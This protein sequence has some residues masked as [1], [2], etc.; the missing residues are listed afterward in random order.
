M[1]YSLR[2]RWLPTCR[3]PQ[4]RRR[5]KWSVRFPPPIRQ[6]GFG[7]GSS[8]RRSPA[9]NYRKPKTRE[10]IVACAAPARQGIDAWAERRLHDRE[11]ERHSW[12]AAPEGRHRRGCRSGAPPQGRQNPNLSRWRRNWPRVDV[13]APRRRRLR[14]NRGGAPRP[15]NRCVLSSPFAAA[16]TRA[17]PISFFPNV[18]SCIV[19]WDAQPRSCGKSA[20]MSLIAAELDPEITLLAIQ[21]ENISMTCEQNHTPIG[22]R[23]PG[24]TILERKTLRV[25]TGRARSSKRS[26]R[27]ARCA[28]WGRSL[29]A[30]SRS[31]CVVAATGRAARSPKAATVR[32]VAGERGRRSGRRWSTPPPPP[33]PANR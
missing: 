24:R 31:P 9:P 22:V 16:P 1:R 28:L 7:M 21:I 2:R 19:R 23:S 32:G 6:I 18:N 30:P 3:R 33:F 12:P 17:W 15:R 27:A 13:C 4:S 25:P 11:R 10:G 5:S 26:E 20:R 8:W 14:R 29:A